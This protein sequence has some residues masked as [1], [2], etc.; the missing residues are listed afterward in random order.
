M[1]R[2]WAKS[3]KLGRL[4]VYAHSHSL[5]RPYITVGTDRDAE[6]V[7]VGYGTPGCDPVVGAEISLSGTRLGTL[8]GEVG[9]WLERKIRRRG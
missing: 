3:A 7:A 5:N 9:W 4:S 6:Y 1:A 8:I 2:Y